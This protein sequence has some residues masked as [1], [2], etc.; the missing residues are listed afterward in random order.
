MSNTPDP[1]W[2]PAISTHDDKEYDY[3]EGDLCIAIADLAYADSDINLDDWQRWIIREALKQKDGKNVYN[4]FLVSVGRQCGKTTLAT[5]MCLYF[6]LARVR[7]PNVFVV[8]STLNQANIAYGRLSN[9]INNNPDIKKRFRPT[10]ETRGIATK[11]GGRLNV[12]PAKSAALQGFSL[13]NALVDEIHLVR[14]E[15]WDALVIGLGQQ[16]NSLLFGITTAGSEESILLK[17]LYEKAQVGADGLGAAIWQADEG[18]KT[19]DIEQLKKANP[20]LAIGRMDEEQVLREVASLPEAE[21]IRYRLNRFVAAESP[22]IPSSVWKNLER[23]GPKP[24]KP[25][26]LCL[27]IAPGWTGASVAASWLDEGDVHVEVLA[28]VVRPTWQQ[29][30]DLI[31]TIAKQ[32]YHTEIGVNAFNGGEVIGQLRQSGF[33]VYKILARDEFVAPPLVYQAMVDGAVRKP[34]LALLD[35]QMLRVSRKE[36]GNDYK[37]VKP[38]KE[39]DIDCAMSVIYAIYLSLIDERE[40]VQVF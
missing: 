3:S 32:V 27:D 34:D 35:Y 19:N 2:A 9:L 6:M 37:L 29:A 7:E 26:K 40:S 4:Q 5:A 30:Y 25:V 17:R 13:T 16:K 31:E 12:A 24:D 28:S 38:T 15:V 20:A 10:T 21:A 1:K 36:K 18:A 8:A 11:Q 14:P 23:V 22:F 39:I 33:N